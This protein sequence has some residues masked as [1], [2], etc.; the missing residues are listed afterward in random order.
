MIKR[1]FEE[2]KNPELKCYRLDNHIVK[3]RESV[4]VV[5]PD[6]WNQMV[7][8]PHH[9]NSRVIAVQFIKTVYLCSRCGIERKPTEYRIKKLMQGPNFAK[10][11]N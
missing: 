5:S 10:S 6:K 8:T 3:V 4:G 11:Q 9:F 1:F 2:R 7:D